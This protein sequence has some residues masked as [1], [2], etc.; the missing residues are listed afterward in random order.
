MT[1]PLDPPAA[2]ATTLDLPHLRV[3]RLE[4][5]ARATRDAPTPPYLGTTLRGAIGQAL[6]HL[7]CTTGAPTCAGC[8]R[9]A[10]C[11]YGAVWEGGAA[12]DLGELARGADAPRP[13]VLAW[14]PPGRRPGGL[15]R[16][17]P[18]RFGVTVLGR[19]A[20]WL[21]YL[22]IALRDGLAHGLG[23]DRAPFALE[24]VELAT[25]DAPITL[26]ADGMLV[27]WTT[28]PTFTLRELAERSAAHITERAS[29]TFATPLSITVENRRADVPTL[30]ALTQRLSERIERLRRAWSDHPGDEPPLDWRA[31]VQ[32][33]THVP[34][35]AVDTHIHRFERQSRRVDE[36]VPM[37]GVV[38]RLELGRLPAPLARLLSAGALVH[39]GKQATFGFGRLHLESARP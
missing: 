4:V 20:R 15:R 7:A 10:A 36:P 14:E 33:A 34:V 1:A 28:L 2:T 21:D 22:V 39:V 5:R 32:L 24:R 18:L 30:V 37:A 6:R 29:L 8:P 38:G 12:G 17:D 9:L 23:S 31:L 19:A 3:T 13:Y 27:P 26:W 35:L 11:A 16:G 25:R